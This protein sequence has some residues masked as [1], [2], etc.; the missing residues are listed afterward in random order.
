MQ[1]T[2]TRHAEKEKT[3]E[4]PFLTKKGIKQAKHLSKRLKKERFNEFYSSDLNRTKQT[5]KIISRKIRIN[6]KIEK[7]LNE[8]KSEILTKN[9]TKWSKEEKS[10]YNKLTAFLKKILKNPQDKKSILII[11]HGITNRIILS[12][13][14]N[15]KLKTTLPF[16]QSE[17][18]INSIYWADKFKNWRL[19]IWND[20]NHIPK[21]LRIKQ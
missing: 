13:L 16:R 5:A 11:A 1:I 15:L 6:P 17:G 10:H 3:G 2:F 7:S 9:K 20:N 8:F 21:K 19:T 4:D 18:A 14:L 12:Y